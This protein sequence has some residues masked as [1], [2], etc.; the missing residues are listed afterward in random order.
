MI[1]QWL[2]R[3]ADFRKTETVNLFDRLGEANFNPPTAVAV[4]P[5]DCLQ[6]TRQPKKREFRMTPQLHIKTFTKARQH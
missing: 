5:E 4:F 2:I 1:T 3:P 6:S